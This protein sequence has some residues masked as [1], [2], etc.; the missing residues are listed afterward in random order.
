MTYPDWHD[1]DGWM[2]IVR[3]IKKVCDSLGVRVIITM[4]HGQM[5]YDTADDLEE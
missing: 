4:E 3:E 5:D 2:R 1:V